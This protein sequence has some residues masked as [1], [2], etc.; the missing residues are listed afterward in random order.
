MIFVADTDIGKL[1]KVQIPI[2]QLKY[3]VTTISFS[4]QNV[5]DALKVNLAG[6]FNIRNYRFIFCVGF[7]H[8]HILDAILA[9]ADISMMWL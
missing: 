1:Q 3:T 2:Y 8:C 6:I 4:L 9:G 7:S 5:I